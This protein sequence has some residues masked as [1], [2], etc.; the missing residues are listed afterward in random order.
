[1][2]NFRKVHRNFT[3]NLKLRYKLSLVYMAVIIVPI[4]VVGEYSYQKSEGFMIKEAESSLEKELNQ[5]TEDINYKL[6]LSRKESDA[7]FNN[8]QLRTAL[9][10]DFSQ[11][12]QGLN[13]AYIDVIDPTFY[14]LRLIQPSADIMIYTTNQSLLSGNRNIASI[15]EIADNPNYKKLLNNEI[16]F[17]WLPTSSMIKVNQNSELGYYTLRD[18]AGSTDKQYEKILT[19]SRSINSYNG[20]LLGI[21]DM[22]IPVKMLDD[23]FKNLKLSEECAGI[24]IDER[25]QVLTSFGHG[26]IADSSINTVLSTSSRFG[27]IKD[28]DHILVYGKTPLNH[29]TI[30]ISYPKSYITDQIASIRNITRLTIVLSIVLVAIISFLLANLITKRLD[31]LMDKIKH[32]RD[33]GNTDITFNT[34]GHD[35]V[36]DIGK[37]LNTMISRINKLTE[38][39]LE[40]EVAKKAMEMEILQAQINPHFLYNSLSS[41][42]WAVNTPKYKDLDGVIDSLVR[43]YRLSLNKGK[44]TIRVRDELQLI[45]EYVNVQKFTYDANYKV[46]WDIDEQVA[47]CACMKLILQPFVENAI[48]HGLNPKKTGGLLRIAAYLEGSSIFFI[49]DDNGLGFDARTLNSSASSE[50]QQLYKG[51]GIENSRKRIKLA[52][53]DQYDVTIKSQPSAGTR[54]IIEIPAAG[55]ATFKKQSSQI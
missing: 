31:K 18:K 32:I 40:A 9:M 3:F 54:V 45:R 8:K 20:S 6:D 48:L 39:Q 23:V 19:F 42:K 51:F 10:T 27:T 30:L 16:Q 52:Y 55:P 4:V 14:N 47:D 53:G 33:T 41:M 36:A 50:L 12:I 17:S 37:L 43:F 44:E 15:D 38:K 1:M 35:E 5:V 34:P 46:E 25:R 28:K 11:D 49:I 29:A 7:L 22:Y 21:A 24:Y 2:I 13:E 26:S